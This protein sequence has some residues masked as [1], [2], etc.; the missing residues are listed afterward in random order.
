M[1][2]YHWTTEKRAEEI[3]KKGLRK[4]SFIC[5][6]PEDWRGEVCLSI[7][8]DY[9]IDWDNRDEHAKWQGIVHTAIS[10]KKISGLASL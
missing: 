2:V 7:E 4:W 9:E 3:L 10:P 8:L 6:R 5:R 1:T